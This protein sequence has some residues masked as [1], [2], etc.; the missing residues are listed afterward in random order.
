MNRFLRRAT[1]A[2]L[3]L[4]LTVPL[5]AAPAA[6]SYALGEDLLQKDVE[7][8]EGTL[9]SS[10]VFW[11]TSRSDLRQENLI[12][13]TPNGEVTPVVTYGDTLTSCLT[14]GAAAKALEEQ[15]YRVAAG[16]NGDFY[17]VSTGLPIG[18]VVSEGELKSSDG[19]YY[20]IGFRADGTAILGKPAVSVSADLG[21]ART[22]EYGYE[23]QVARKIAGVNKARVSSGGIYL[24]T[25]D[26]NARHTTGNTEPGVDVICSVEE[27]RLSIGE[28][29]TLRVEQVAQ[30][31]A[32]TAIEPGQV[33]LSVNAKSDSYYVDALAEETEGNTITLTI[34]GNEGW[35]DVEYAVGALYSLLSDGVVASGL[36]NDAGPR[37]AVGQKADGTLVFY[38]IDG[39]QSGHSI[40]AS[41]TQVA[42]R[43]AELGCVNALC[44]D[45]GGSTT[46]AV[47]EPDS[48]TAGT[49]NSPSGGAQRSV[50]NHIFLVSTARPS[51]RLSHFYVDP[52]SRCVLAGSSVTVNINAVD[53]RYIPMDSSFSASASAGELEKLPDKREY[54][55]AYRLT[56]PAE[57][58]DVTVTASKSGKEGSAVVTAVVTP[59][60]ITVKNGS[61][62]ISSLTISPGTTLKLTA[63]AIYNHLPLQADDNAFT[64]YYDGTGADVAADGTVTAAAPGEGILTVSAGDRS[65]TIPV[66]VSRIPLQTLEDFEEGAPTSGDGTFGVTLD[67]VSG[68][69]DVKLGR[70]SGK[71]SYTLGADGTAE[72][73]FDRPYPVSAAYSQLNLWLRG[74]GSGNGLYLLTSDGS[75]VSAT[76]IC[77]L[78][79]DEWVQTVTPLPAGTS[80]IVGIRVTGTPEYVEDELGQEMVTYPNGSGTLY[81]DQLTASYSGLVDQR[82]PVITAEMTEGTLSARISDDGDGAIP[83]A[84]VSVTCDG[85]ALSFTYDEKTGKL[86][87]VLP[88][89]DGAAH[90]VT[91]TARD[92]SG[93]MG[94]A[95][96]DIPVGEDYVPG[97]TDTQDYW[98]A[99]YVDYLYAAG[100]T[101]GY[102]DGTFRPNQNIT[103]QQFAVMLFRYLGLN[104]SDYEDLS[105]P[106]ADN[107]QIADYA[108]TAVKALYS[109][110][111]IG[112]TEKNG[113]LYFNPG[114]S[115]TRAQAAAMIGRTQ[116]K[117]YDEAELTFADGAAIPAYAAPYIRTMAAQGIIGGYTDGTFKPSANITRGQM[118]KI[119]FNLR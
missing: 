57:G 24:Y 111:V 70:Q 87:A 41:L 107:A 81:L 86:T 115:L 17:N 64:W 42:E 116:E 118:A 7:V 95:S 33:V 72:V 32:A 61:T 94:R 9:L 74:D 114:G 52:E 68:A 46:L 5:L 82:V 44:L 76:E 96:C 1:S 83:K 47:T 85:K 67:T 37:T 50:S 97:F 30:A 62:A 21:Y 14:V 15:G 38:T 93:N 43:L 53:T 49:V 65:V 63:S 4:A 110:G 28:T 105:L 119:L 18:L 109:L 108:R 71:L 91:V 117:G 26:F 98:A 99:H 60:A 8:N 92:A 77:G 79:F 56:T 10:N 36:S 34:T 35:E 27:G 23:T 58:G 13:Y 45:G 39:R 101:T 102:A 80:A 40:G 16:V 25:Y 29:V 11:S 100:I 59:D 55:A 31:S 113:K 54:G 78:T 48:V 88:E 2:L 66:T 12:T 106:F 51:G 3:T 22:D 20:A 19:G 73:F 84:N 103:R 112:G 6:A 75:T 89:A 104:E 69:N 90:R